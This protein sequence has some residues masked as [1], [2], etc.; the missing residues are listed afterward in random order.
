MFETNKDL[1]S[2]DIKKSVRAEANKNNSALAL[3]QELKIANFKLELKQK[4]FFQ[5]KTDLSY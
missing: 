3:K 1:N 4:N 2:F 5:L